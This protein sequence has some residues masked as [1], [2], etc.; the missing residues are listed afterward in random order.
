MFYIASMKKQK[1]F[2]VLK[3]KS[4][5][6]FHIWKLLHLLETIQF[7]FFYISMIW[8]LMFFGY[9]MLNIGAHFALIQKTLTKIIKPCTLKALNIPR[10]ENNSLRCEL[11]F[12]DSLKNFI[13]EWKF[14]ETLRNY[15]LM[16][17]ITKQWIE[18]VLKSF[19]K[20]E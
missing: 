4:E 9:N 16:K 20:I 15:L 10:L 6:I 18:F 1:F 2:V 11:E 19:D 3:G 17:T 12:Y 8:E 5:Q 13:I 7:L 14:F